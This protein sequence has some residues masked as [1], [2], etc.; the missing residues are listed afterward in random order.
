MNQQMKKGPARDGKIPVLR[1]E[2][3]NRQKNL[4]QKESHSADGKEP[5]VI[6]DPQAQRFLPERVGYKNTAQIFPRKPFLRVGE[7]KNRV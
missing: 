6:G 2:E 1:S 3:Q 4:K 7:F 5:G